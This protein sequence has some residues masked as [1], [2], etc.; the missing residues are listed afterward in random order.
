VHRASFAFS[1]ASTSRVA[2]R[3]AAGAF[4][5]S[6]ESPCVVSLSR[7]AVFRF[8]AIVLLGL[9]IAVL[10]PALA[11]RHGLPGT[12]LPKITYARPAPDFVFEVKG[13]RTSLAAFAGHPVVLNFWA[14]WCEPCSAEL[15]ALARLR[16]SYGQDVVLIAVSDESRDVT[17]P[18]LRAHGVDALAVSDPGRKIFDLYSVTPLPVTLVL[19]RD[20]TVTHV[21]VGELDWPELQTAVTAAS[22]TLG[23]SAVLAR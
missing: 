10:S 13:T 12:G 1:R 19:A 3:I 6:R 21:S 5:R 16:T 20:G 9:Q 17:A 15:P 8:I 2:D 23:S 14:T 22:S 4:G 7:R 18:F 11:R